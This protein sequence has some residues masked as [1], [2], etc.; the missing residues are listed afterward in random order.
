MVEDRDLLNLSRKGDS[1]QKMVEDP[2]L[3]LRSH[4]RQAGS[5][6]R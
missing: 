1:Q 2:R 5:D 6:K 4:R 3:S